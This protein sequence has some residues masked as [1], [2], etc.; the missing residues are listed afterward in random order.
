VTASPSVTRPYQ[1]AR[2]STSGTLVT[3][4][5]RSKD[6]LEDEW[7]WSQ[8]QIGNV[9]L[10]E[11]VCRRA[12]DSDHNRRDLAEFLKKQK[13]DSG[14]MNDLASMI[15]DL[16]AEKAGVKGPEEFVAHVV[17]RILSAAR[18]G[19]DAAAVR[20]GRTLATTIAM[21][22][23]DKFAPSG[24]SHKDRAGM[25]LK[26]LHGPPVTG[27]A[28]S[29]TIARMDFSG[30]QFRDCRFDRVMWAN[31]RLDE[32]TVFDACH[33]VGGMIERTNGLGLAEFKA[34]TWDTEAEAL[35]RLAEAREG[36]RKYGHD[37][38]KADIGRVIS[39]FV[40]RGGLLQTVE[41]RNLRRGTI[42]GSKHADDVI[43]ALISNVLESHH[44][45]GVAEGGYNVREDVVDAVRF[46][47]SN[48]VLTGG[49]KYV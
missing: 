15:V 1:F 12:I 41:Q 14:Q 19:S 24:T 8:E 37:D 49:L 21:K 18:A 39:K 10:A 7:N 27:V 46:F 43:E 6:P 5:T 34:C 3:F 48:G 28:F 30:V 20:D 45:S 31:V 2:L 38:L 40:S 42:R 22:A 4:E 33:F 11:W 26:I 16:A 13:L 36:R 17:D 35:I 44:I 23:V 29:G 47:T 32:R 25:L 9:F